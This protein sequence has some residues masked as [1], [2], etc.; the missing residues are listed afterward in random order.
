[1]NRELKFRIWLHD[2]KKWGDVSCLE[3]FNTTGKLEYLYQDQPYTIQQYT[4]LKDKNG[5]E[6]YEG[7]M[8]TLVD[9]DVEDVY[10][11]IYHK[12]GFFTVAP[13]IDSCGFIPA[14]GTFARNDDYKLQVIG[15]VYSNPYENL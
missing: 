11:V 3:V 4:G 14:L 10:Q 7:D 12:D 15:N 1:M 6:I 5:K 8:V 2:A 9:C 13:M